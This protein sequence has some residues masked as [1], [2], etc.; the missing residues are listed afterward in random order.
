MLLFIY[1]ETASVTFFLFEF[2]RNVGKGAVFTADRNE[3]LTL[4]TP[5]V[6]GGVLEYHRGYD[7]VAAN[8]S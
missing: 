4:E 8:R 6:I 3:E 5:P 1:L 7:S 2:R